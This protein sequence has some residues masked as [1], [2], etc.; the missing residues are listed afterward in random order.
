MGV[1]ELENVWKVYING[2]KTPVLKGITL[3]IEEGE[4]VSIMGPSGSGKSTLLNIMGLLDS[5]TEGRVI[6]KGMDVSRLDENSKAEIRR[7]YIGFVF[8]SFNLIP[9]L[10][11]LE[12]VELPLLF[13]GVPKKKR[14]RIAIKLLNEVGLGNRMYY[15]P[16]QLSGGQQ[17]RV[18]IARALA[19][20]PV[21]I[22]ADEPTGNLDSAT[23]EKILNLFDSLHDRGK[24]LVVVTHDI[25]VA[26]RAERVVKIKDGR[27]IE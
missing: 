1:I 19:N 13:E 6:L 3:N 22:L 18:A 11:A 4:Y 14:E 9:S 21:V 2:V 24:A 25:E 20:D 27:L 17:Q 10:T 16:N 8:Q 26:E 7:K 5:P 15:Y 12:N 23:G